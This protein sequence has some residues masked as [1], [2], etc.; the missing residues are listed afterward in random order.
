MAPVLILYYSRHGATAQLARA[1][2]VGVEAG[3]ATAKI[4][5]VPP[6]SSDPNAEQP[7]DPATGPPF[8]TLDDLTG[9]SAL[10][11]GSPT[12]FGNMA[13]PVKHFLDSTSGLWLNGALINKPAC[14][15]TSTSSMHGVGKK[16]MVQIVVQE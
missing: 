7:D 10:A 15:F 5:T 13:A 9:C 16:K 11:L 2:G 6:I 4:R 8:V 3:G 14:E 12:R 1:I